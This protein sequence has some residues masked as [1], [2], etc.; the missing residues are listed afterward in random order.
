[1]D[2]RSRYPVRAAVEFP[3]EENFRCGLV[4]SL[5]RQPPGKDR[6]TIFRQVGELMVQSHLGY[7]R[8]GLDSPETDKMVEALLGMGPDKGIYGGR[9]SGGGS[10][11]TVVIFLRKKALPLLDQLRCKIHFSKNGPLPLIF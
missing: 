9:V 6:E 11:G 7:S 8:M 1:V 10:G 5:L 2:Q 4:A 3:V